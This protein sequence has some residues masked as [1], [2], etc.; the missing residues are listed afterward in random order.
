MDGLIIWLMV[1]NLMSQSAFSLLAP[2]YPDMAE[3]KKG[4]NST[5]VGLVM[6]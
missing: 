5:I 6:A 1:V 2:F 4:L 3:K